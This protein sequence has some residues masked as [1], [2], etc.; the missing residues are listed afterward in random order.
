MAAGGLAH[1]G[2]EHAVEVGQEVAR[3]LEAS[4]VPGAQAASE[5]RHFLG[6]TEEPSKLQ[7]TSRIG[8]V[9]TRGAV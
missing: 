4:L 3:L 1:L 6:H 2:V 9:S 8:K 7:A 5:Q